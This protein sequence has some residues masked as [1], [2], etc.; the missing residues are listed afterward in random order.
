MQGFSRRYAYFENSAFFFHPERPPN[1]IESASVIHEFLALFD[2]EERE[3]HVVL[4]CSREYGEFAEQAPPFGIRID[5]VRPDI[6]AAGL[7]A[8]AFI[9][10]SRRFPLYVHVDAVSAKD[11]FRAHDMARA[12]LDLFTD[13]CRF[14]KHTAHLEAMPSAVVAEADFNYAY[15]MK[16]R[17]NSMAFHADRDPRQI[18]GLVQTTIEILSGWHFT[19]R[20]R[21]N[22]QKVLDYHET[23]L[24]A[25][26]PQNQLLNLWSS[27]EGFLPPLGRKP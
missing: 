14:A 16:G 18:A 19:P 13:V 5:D 6:T 23:A 1:R 26:T 3:R 8:R 11:K 17:P 25:K 10:E 4:R 27:V 24:S 7:K 22:F 20:L 15:F 12:R 9:G 21:Q 2:R